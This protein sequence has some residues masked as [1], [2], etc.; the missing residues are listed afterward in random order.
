[1]PRKGGWG[2]AYLLSLLVTNGLGQVILHLHAL[3]LPFLALSLV[4]PKVQ[5]PEAVVEGALVHLLR[6]HLSQLLPRQGSVFGF[7]GFLLRCD[8]IQVRLLLEP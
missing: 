7:A 8:L 1:M 4:G 3:P 2:R 5:A 6:T